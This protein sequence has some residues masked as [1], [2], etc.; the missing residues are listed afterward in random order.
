MTDANPYQ[1]PESELAPPAEAVGGSLERGLSGDYDFSVFELFNQGWEVSKGF[2]ATFWGAALIMIGVNMAFSFA[3]IPFQNSVVLTMI[4]QILAIV[5]LWPLNAGFM[6]LGIHRAAGREVN[7]MQITGYFDRTVKIVLLNLLMV[8]LIGIGFILLVLPGIYLAIAY[9]F[10]LPLMLDK[11]MGVWEAL[12]SSRKT[13][14]HKWFSFF[15]FALL[16]LVAVM[17]AGM[18]LVIPLIW[19]LPLIV[20]AYGFLYTKILG[21]ESED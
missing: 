11:N 2:K 17:V 1:A 10:A 6:M 7:S 19:V 13:V 9:M 20:V 16:I 5:I 12:E 21:V 15:G 4:I 8:V 3:S 14:S 18:L